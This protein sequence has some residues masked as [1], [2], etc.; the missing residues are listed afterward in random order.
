MITDPFL[1][2]LWLWALARLSTRA[3][4]LELV[5]LP[6]RYAPRPRA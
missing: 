2:H 4:E 3:L 6:S 5:T 1:S